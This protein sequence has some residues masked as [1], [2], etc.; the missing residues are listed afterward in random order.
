MQVLKGSKVKFISA[1]VFLLTSFWIPLWFAHSSRSYCLCL[2]KKKKPPAD[3]TLT[4]LR[5]H[6][7]LD[8]SGRGGLGSAQ[9][10][11]FPVVQQG[12]GLSLGYNNHRCLFPSP[13]PQSP[14]LLTVRSVPL[15]QAGQ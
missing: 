7:F 1:V 6:V 11:Y 13:R 14:L 3:F 12:C 15:H 2:K 10:F 5:L 9:L 4:E 8:R